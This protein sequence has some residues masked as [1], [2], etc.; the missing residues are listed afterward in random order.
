MDDENMELFGE[1]SSIPVGYRWKDLTD[2]DGYDLV[3]QYESTL[4]LLS[5]Q[6]DLIG[7]IYTKA[8]N[9]IDKPVYLKK[10]ITMIDEEQWLI[11][12]GDVKG[13]IYESILEKNGQDKKVVLV[14]TLP[15]VH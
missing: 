3:K 2:L 14:S 13:A 1:D 8:Q 12:D 6:D 11:M 7:T 5:Q 9:K 10:V 15:H 4:K